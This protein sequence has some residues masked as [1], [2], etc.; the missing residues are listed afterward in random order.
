MNTWI[1]YINLILQDR[2]NNGIKTECFI[3]DLV[4]GKCMF[5]SI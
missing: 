5:E 1:D 2:K 4:R 3:S